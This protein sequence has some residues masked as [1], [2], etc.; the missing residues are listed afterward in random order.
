MA[1]RASSLCAGRETRYTNKIHLT[2][3]GQRTAPPEQRAWFTAEP[4]RSKPLYSFF[5]FFFV[6]IANVLLENTVHSAWQKNCNRNGGGG[7]EGGYG[8]LCGTWI[9]LSTNVCLIGLSRWN[10]QSELYTRKCAVVDL[11]VYW[12]GPGR[13]MKAVQWTWT[14]AERKDGHVHWLAGC[15]QRQKDETAKG[16][17][18]TKTIMNISKKLKKT[19]LFSRS[20]SQK[21]EV[22]DRIEDDQTDG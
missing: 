2:P 17:L 22:K 5:S 4:R 9:L 20:R 7:G 6:S 16:Q 10:S 11:P 21:F 15:W 1:G 13:A 12:H 14:A 3:W 8:A 18:H 19:F